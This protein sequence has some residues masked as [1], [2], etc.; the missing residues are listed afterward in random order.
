[1]RRLVDRFVQRCGLIAVEGVFGDNN[2][3]FVGFVCL[4]QWSV[5]VID[6]VR[7]PEEQFLLFAVTLH[8]K[9][10]TEGS[11]SSSLVALAAD[12]PDI[13]VDGNYLI[14]GLRDSVQCIEW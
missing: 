7:I 8:Q 4:N 3:V 5:G 10:P 6:S 1:L 14:R 2:G 12:S 11:V 13:S 9:H